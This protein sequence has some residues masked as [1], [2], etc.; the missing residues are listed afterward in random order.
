MHS[1]FTL[2]KGSVLRPEFSCSCGLRLGSFFSSPRGQSRWVLL[3]PEDQ[4]GGHLEEGLG[5]GPRCL[6]D[7]ASEAFWD[8]AS[9]FSAAAASCRIVAHCSLAPGDR[10]GRPRRPSE[11]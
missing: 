5:A 2:C 10:Q 6:V 11:F 8:L 4:G 7:L 9:T 1:W 3:D